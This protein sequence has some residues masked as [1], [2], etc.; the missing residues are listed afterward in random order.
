MQKVA[1]DYII[2]IFLYFDDQSYNFLGDLLQTQDKINKEINIVTFNIFCRPTDP[3]LRN[4]PSTLKC[5][6][7]KSKASFKNLND[8]YFYH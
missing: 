6:V 5:C 8:K 2:I 3:D 7:R 4:N 1:K